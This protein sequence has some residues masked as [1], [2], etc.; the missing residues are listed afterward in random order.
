MAKEITVTFEDGGVFEGFA[1]TY[2]LN[3]EVTYYFSFDRDYRV[4]L[5]DGAI[6]LQEY[7]NAGAWYPID[8]IT[9][10]DV[11]EISGGGGGDVTKDWVNENF[12]KKS[13]DT[14]T[15]A[16]KFNF[17][18]HGVTL[19]IEEQT[20]TNRTN[21]IL[22]GNI[23]LNRNDGIRTMGIYSGSTGSGS[24]ALYGNYG[25][26][27]NYSFFSL[28]GHPYNS[29]GG[30]NTY[31]SMNYNQ[32][33]DWNRDNH[34][35]SI[36][37]KF[38]TKTD[39]FFK[40]S[41]YLDYFTY[42]RDTTNND[43]INILIRPFGQIET[44]GNNGC[45]QSYTTNYGASI[46][47]SVKYGNN[48]ITAYN[49]SGLP[50]SINAQ[51]GYVKINSDSSRIEFDAPYIVGIASGT[52]GISMTANSGN[53]VLQDRLGAIGRTSNS[54]TN[55]YITNNTQNVYV[56]SSQTTASSDRRDELEAILE[57]FQIVY[58]ILDTAGIPGASKMAEY[59]SKVV[60]WIYDNQN[61]VLK[62]VVTNIKNLIH[63]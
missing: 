43:K 2:T 10:F 15:G 59:T 7:R 31:I 52:N 53:I 26:N 20:S 36:W 30:D 12:V 42:V 56:Q 41:V 61:G 8:I 46:E 60:L 49:Y 28:C 6:S 9:G 40:W 19:S 1:N 25:S 51:T 57:L 24:I 44:Y 3:N 55:T 16:L 23:I 14:M 37:T 54:I 50:L 4:Q 18:N 45:F 29:A 32:I 39:F 17:S 62:P 38:E 21:I 22:N 58:D 33:V 11:S 48:G 5:T 27:A 47:T 13:G 63:D 34:T 35:W